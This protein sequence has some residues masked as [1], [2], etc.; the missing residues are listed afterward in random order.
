MGALGIIS[1]CGST[2]VKIANN[3]PKI[4]NGMPAQVPIME[5]MSGTPLP[6]IN[7]RWKTSKKISVYQSKTGAL[8]WHRVVIPLNRP[9]LLKWN[10]TVAPNWV[11]VVLLRHQLQVGQN[12]VEIT[13]AY[14]YAPLIPLPG[15]LPST[16]EI[17]KTYQMMVETA[18]PSGGTT[19]QFPT[20]L[21]YYETTQWTNPS[22]ATPSGGYL[23][24]PPPTSGSKAC[25]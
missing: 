13:I 14:P 22:P 16:I 2:N 21:P 6:A 12:D 20:G 15:L 18:Q 25:S 11:N 4:V 17:T 23:T 19:S 3:A 10:T 7:W 8:P 9:F 5:S 24:Q 1:G